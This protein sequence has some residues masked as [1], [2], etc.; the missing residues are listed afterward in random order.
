MPEEKQYHLEVQCQHCKVKGRLNFSDWT[1]EF[2]GGLRLCCPRCKK[3]TVYVGV[4]GQNLHVER[5]KAD[6]EQHGGK[7]DEKRSESDA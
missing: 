5:A 1:V 7:P 2:T 6:A 4:F 3:I